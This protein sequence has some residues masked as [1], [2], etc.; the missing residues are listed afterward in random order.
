M[1]ASKTDDV[2]PEE[3]PCIRRPVSIARM[4]AAARIANGQQ[5]ERS[6]IMLVC[7][8]RLIGTVASQFSE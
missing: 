6:A 3:E 8:R 5:N 1:H 2:S 4:V 7:A